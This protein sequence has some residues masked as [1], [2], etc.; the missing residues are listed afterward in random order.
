MEEM[1]EMQGRYLDVW[2]EAV[3]A[4]AAVFERRRLE[5]SY[6]H[7]L[8]VTDDVLGRL[9]LRN[10]AGQRDIDRMLTR[11]IDR[12]LAEMPPRARG[13]FPQARTV[14]Q[15]LDGI[16]AVQEELLLVLQ[17]MVHWDRLLSAPWD[18]RS[19]ATDE[20]RARRTA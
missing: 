20:P 18:E 10:M 17:R 5:R 2:T 8:A 15:A 12:A 3:A 9:E 13:R 1:T 11:H 7:M 4:E 19:E 14:Q 6:R 16:F